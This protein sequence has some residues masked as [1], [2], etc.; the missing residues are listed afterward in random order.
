MLKLQVGNWLAAMMMAPMILAG[1]YCEAKLN[2]VATTTD[3]G[4]LAEAV[5]G[6]EVSVESIAKGT[7][8][9]HFIEPKPSYMLKVSKADLLILNGLSLEEG[10]LPNLVQGGRNP[11]VKAGAKG[12]LD[13]GNE[14][15]P[16]DVPQGAV[17]RAAGDVHPFG[18]PHYVLDPVRMGRLAMVV[19]GRLGELDPAHAAKFDGN[20]KAFQKN[21]DDKTKSWL[22]RI[23]KSGVTQVIAYHNDL[24]YFLERFGLRAA[25]FLEPKPG[26]PPT[27]Q[28]LLEVS[29]LIKREKIPLVLVEN[30]FDTKIADRL[31]ADVPSV[32]VRV[33][34]IAVGSKPELKSTADVIEQLVATVE[35]K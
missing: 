9:P 1:G 12:Y 32:K 10:W 14:A 18:N 2:V 16:L 8:D 27:A 17:S 4:A 20:A 35:G 11:K 5:G 28:H 26:I 21:L 13:L 3:L 19:A 24:R 29:G 34:G 23:K 22:E 7:Q 6:D 30:F 25:D 15:E 33:V 31:A